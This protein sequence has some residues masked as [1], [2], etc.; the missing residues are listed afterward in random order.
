MDRSIT[1][2]RF[3]S[4]WR[5][6]PASRGCRRGRGAARWVSPGLAV[7]LTGACAT[8]HAALARR[9][10]PASGGA[11]VVGDV[12]TGGAAGVAAGAGG[13]AAGAGPIEPPGPPV[14]TLLHGVVDAPRVA[15]C[16][17]PH[18]G[19]VAVPGGSPL[20]EGGLP[21]GGACSLGTLP[22][23]D[24]ANEDATVYV[25]AGAAE[26]LTALDC[27]GALGRASEGVSGG[28]GAGGAPAAGRGGH[29]QAGSAALSPGAAGAAGAGAGG[30][31]PPSTV[32]PALRARPLVTIPAGTLAFERS[33][34]LVA[35]GCLGGA[36][37]P[38]ADAPGICGAEGGATLAP[39]FARLSRLTEA[40]SVGLMAVHAAT[41]F[42]SDER[43][44]VGLSV[45]GMGWLAIATDLGPGAVGPVP[46]RFLTEVAWQTR[47]P[48]GAVSVVAQRAPPGELEVPWTELLEVAGRAG[49]VA[50]ES[51]ALV[52]VGPAPGVADQ[53]GPWNPSQ[54]VLVDPAGAQE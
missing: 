35:R 25:V 9:P 22:G 44:S 29:E 2:T 39:V 18:R 16:V 20:P 28:G 19:G 41:P 37:T 31:S 34:L 38:D 1:R 13:S 6:E 42:T 32:P 17:S 51:V 43:L 49:P 48:A 46:P 15:F 3:A 50:G 26:V 4:P 30:L 7:L 54:V 52:V 45:S 23:V 36:G 11:G 10:R 47:V 27:V 40:G 24:V 8:D 33:T 14:I 21:F 12:S 5:P 53:G